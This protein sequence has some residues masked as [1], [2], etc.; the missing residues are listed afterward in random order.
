MV[1][2]TEE[3]ANRPRSKKSSLESQSK[4]KKPEKIS[5][6][7]SQEEYEKKIIELAKQGLT[8]EKIGETLRN[9]GI[10]SKEH[11]GKISFILKKNKLYVNPDLKNITEKMENINKHYIKNKQDK[12]AMREGARFASHLRRL[13]T[14]YKV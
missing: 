5:K 4:E 9:S 7:I 3:K 11:E 14:Y 10:H 12:R 1:N 6:K 8:S 13:K 2:N